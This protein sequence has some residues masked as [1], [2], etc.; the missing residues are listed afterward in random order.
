[1]IVFIDSETLLRLHG[2]F[3]PDSLL[4]DDASL[5]LYGHDETEDFQFPPSLVVKPTETAQVA[6]L[7]K[8]ANERLFP[9][10]PRGG[11]T[12]LSGGALPVEGGVLLS[13]EKM[14]RILEIDRENLVAVVE[15]GVITQTLQEEVEKI[16]LFYPPDPASRGSCTIGGNIAECAGGPRALKYGVT[17]DYVLGVQAVLPSGEMVE[18]GG[19]LLKDAAGYNMTQLFVGSEGTLGILTRAVL[20]L[21]PYPPLRK[22]L[23]VPFS[24]ME[25]A[26]MAVARIFQAGVVPC[27]CEF[28]E[29]DVVKRIEE[30]KEVRIPFSDADAQLLIEIDGQYEELLDRDLEKIAGVCQ[31]LN[32]IDILVA[33]NPIRQKELWDWRRAAG[34]AVKSISIYKEEDTVV[35]RVRLPE[36]IRGV[37]AI[38]SRYGIR[39]MCYGH[40][41]DGNIHVNVIKGDMDGERWA[42]E[43]H[44]AVQEMFEFTRSLG[45]TLSGEHGIG[46]S[47][48]RYLPIVRTS[49]EIELMRGIKRLFDPNGILN[50]GKIFP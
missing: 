7:M 35:P 44:G 20:R 3:P 40:A 1:M 18:F 46:Y 8:L 41:G 45:G 42:R 47:Q 6:A 13:M 49:T 4:T 16:G 24:R 37:K 10:T 2:I 39:T 34:E 25:D 36:L 15:P 28:M 27:A 30:Y 5:Q 17:K 11:G 33:D 12:G 14:N 50:P 38:A 31:S 29:R 22:T 26:A 21:I 9:V 32:A 43:I 48:K 19:K 23:I